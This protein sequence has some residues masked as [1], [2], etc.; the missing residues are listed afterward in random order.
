VGGTQENVVRPGDGAVNPA[1][2]REKTGAKWALRGT[3]E[4]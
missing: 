2:D 3:I 1:P 4:F